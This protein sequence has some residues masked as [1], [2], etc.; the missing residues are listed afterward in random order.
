MNDYTMT[1]DGRAVTSDAQDPV[2]DPATGEAFA[3]APRATRAHVEEAMSA[4]ERAFPAWKRDLAARRQALVDA[5]GAI[6]ARAEE[7]AKLLSREQGKPLRNATG[8]VL[9]TCAW[10]K[11]FAALP[12][13]PEVLLDDDKRRIA[14]VRKPLGPTVAIAPWNFP[15]VLLAW[16]LGPALLAGNTVVAKPS[17]FTPLSSLLVGEILRPLLPPGVL[18]VL[19]GGGDLGAQL[20]AHP[21]T[22]KVSFTGSV[23]TGKKIAAACADDLKRV[24]LELGGNDPAIVLDDVDPLK[25]VDDLFW[26]AFAN[27][28]QVCVA[29]KRLYVQEKV[30]QTIVDGLAER[31]RSVRVGPATDP[32]AKLGP[33]NN[34]PQ[35]EKLAALV[36]E[37][38]KSGAKI[39]AGGDRPKQPG[40]FYPPTIVAEAHAGMR[41]VDEEQFGTALPVIRF[42]EIDDA[43]RQA[44]ATHFG[45]GG[46]VWTA[47]RARGEAL[48]QELECGTGWVNQHNDLTPIAPFGG[49]KWS[50]IGYEGARWGYEAMTQIQVINSKK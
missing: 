22:R 36:D 10:L 13:E 42:R 5:A 47:D 19:S 25:I 9:A 29:A 41:L 18:N 17:P 21:L 6:K 11:S 50:G 16:K 44:N 15:V 49:S 39:V 34:A 46:S 27:S 38:R 33:I 40:Y 45:L 8:E 30:Y 1:I 14:V 43:L 48:V 24:T 7:I 26:S 31:A 23:M 37:A 20:V 4:A 12:L 2:I 3:S 32:E 35:V 28:G